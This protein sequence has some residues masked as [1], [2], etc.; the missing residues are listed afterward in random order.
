MVVN[1]LLYVDGGTPPP[2]K[3]FGGYYVSGLVVVYSNLLTHR[4][5]Q[6]T[7][8][9]FFAHE[10]A[11]A[12]Q[13]AVV[14]VDGSGDFGDWVHSPKGKAFEETKKK[15]WEEFGKMG[16]ETLPAYEA[17]WENAAQICAFYWG[18]ESIGNAEYGR[19]VAKT[20]NRFKWAEEWLTKR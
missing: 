20:H 7:L 17:L 3:Y 14:N 2:D 9:S 6:N 13:D 4:Q 10:I 5:S 18:A 11:H 1:D 12:H 15:D 16:Y 8:L 19:I